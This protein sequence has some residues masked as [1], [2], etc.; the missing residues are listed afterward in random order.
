M[1]IARLQAGAAVDGHLDSLPGHIIIDSMLGKIIRALLLLGIAVGLVTVVAVPIEMSKMAAAKHWP[2]RKGVITTSYVRP[3][4]GRVGKM[5][6]TTTW[7]PE[8]CG[9]YPDNQA[10]RFCIA[11]V[12]YGEIRWGS[13]KAPSEA[14]AAQYPAGREIDVYYDPEDPK[15][16]I[17]D[18]L[19]PWNEMIALL[20]IGVAGLLL[21]VFL[22]V[23]RKWIEP[24]RY[25]S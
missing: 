17:L 15:E 3:V 2:S 5:G 1:Q 6:T 23:F 22:W 13:W 8:I 4:L 25:R 24:E 16:T 10:D 18:P 19:A 12:R 9:F 20:S 14:V 21:P 11:R 7:R